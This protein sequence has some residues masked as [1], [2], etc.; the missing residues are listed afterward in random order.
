M[1]AF[2]RTALAIALFAAS[3]VSAYAAETKEEPLGMILSA[4]GAKL[5]R[6]GAETPLDA[7]AGDLLFLGDGIR[8]GSG[9]ASFL[10]CP[11]KNIDTLGPST[12]IRA[13]AKEVKVK[14]GS[15]AGQRP[16][17]TCLLPPTLRL[18]VASQQHYG[19]TMT[20]GGSDAPLENIQPD[21]AQLLPAPDPKDAAALAARATIFETHK[22]PSN[23]LAEYQK[24]RTL[25]P[26]AI[27]VQAKIFE[28][29]Q[30]VAV[31]QPASPSG[32][33]TYAVLIGISK[34]KSPELT[35]QFA[36]RDATVFDQLLLSPRG[37]AIPPEN[38][39]L[40]A[41]EHA[42]TAAVRNA[43]QNFLKQKAT[44]ADTVI[45]MIAG[46]GTV[47]QPG[48]K[49]GFILTYDSDPQDLNST[50]LPMAELQSLFEEQVN[51][52][53]RVILFID[54]CRSG[55]IGTI[56]NTNIN[57]DVQHLGE[58]EGDLFGLMASRPRELSLEGPQFGGGHGLFSYYVLKG[59]EGD[60]DA[61]KD[62][63]V[64]VSELIKY[65]TDQVSS[66]SDNKQH[67][68]EFGTYDNSM[69]LSDSTKP[70]IEVTH[71]PRLI[72]SRSGQPLVLASY[73][74]QLPASP[75]TEQAIAT[76][77]SAIG[78]GHVLREQTGNAFAALDRLKALL[79]SDR[80]KDFE[81]QL[82]VTLEDQA[83]E[84]LLRYLTGDE[85]P[86]TEEDF[87]TGAKFMDAALL[88]T[89]ESLYLRAHES[90]FAGRA[91]L[92]E[93]KFADAARLLETAVRIDPTAAYAYNA[94]G[95]A[96]LEQAQYDKAIPAF[97]DAANR[98]QHWSYPLH[99]LALAYME[100]GNYE[101]AIRS[102][103]EAIRLAPRFAYLPYNLGF[104]YQRI[105]RKKEAEVSYRRAIALAPAWPE[106]SNAIGVLEASEG[107]FADAERD[108]RSALQK[109]AHF[110]AARHN[111]GLL[112]ASRPQRKEEAILLWRE[113]LVQDPDYISS[114]LALA[115]SLEPPQAI[116]EY[117]KI[118]DLKPDY[119]AARIALS[120]LLAKAGQTGDAIAQ[121]QEVLKRGPGNV[122]LYERLGDLE[123]SA[124]QSDARSSY[125]SA[126]KLATDSAARTRL[127]KKIND[128]SF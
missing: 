56:K 48:S 34:Y 67:P 78:Q 30:T 35:L 71:F 59:L 39:L 36:E 14:A 23:A 89:P 49:K 118:L 73:E 125:E 107:R 43:F 79:A 9:S 65:V 55:T 115:R 7:S 18:A 122:E 22:L 8:T 57:G 121:L 90:F 38:I 98:A 100:A 72:D 85:V 75:E 110:L 31:A 119:P 70:G 69:K 54:V 96:Y 66:A 58:V 44:K 99:N 41:N 53:G 13:E 11:S 21:V 32:G 117:R 111:L 80:Y 109:D 64:D 95:I 113:N 17:Q 61:N 123:K 128:S 47:E 27:W 86:Q 50:A 40:L 2:H 114:R 103:Q 84:V 82:R 19:V 62:G 25:L 68:R 5:L 101:P 28:L 10:H 92:F 93:K 124:G 105:G 46:H 81:N 120:G 6:A 51:K 33:N 4:P 112:L 91:L 97:R 45:L 24:L 15:I 87:S 116:L 63:K 102:Y 12:E 108:Y 37:G 60:A 104:V 3:G 74:P 126:F 20:R 83:Q 127:K 77:R 94:L 29:Q 76:F 42:T 52:V 1:A 88:L 106:P 16:A 26:D